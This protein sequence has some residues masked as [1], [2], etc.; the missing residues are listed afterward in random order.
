MATNFTNTKNRTPECVKGLKPKHY[1]ISGG[2]YYFWFEVEAPEG[3]HAAKWVSMFRWFEGEW[4]PWVLCGKEWCKVNLD[5]FDP[6]RITY[7]PTC[8]VFAIHDSIN[9]YER[10][11]ATLKSQFYT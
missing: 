6:E 10:E 4:L 9:L 2:F 5:M 3:Y 1:T 7:R 8:N 11:G